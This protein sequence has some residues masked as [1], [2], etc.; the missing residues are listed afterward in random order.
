[1][2]GNL[3]RKCPRG[4]CDGDLFLEADPFEK[5]IIHC[6]LCTRRWDAETGKLLTS[7]EAPSLRGLNKLIHSKALGILN[8]GG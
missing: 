6:T 8:D 3:N 5:L 2:T 7:V 4:C 1:M